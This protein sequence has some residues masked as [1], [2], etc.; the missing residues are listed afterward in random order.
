MTLVTDATGNDLTR[1]LI[2]LAMEVHNEIGPGFKEDV[3]EKA[4]AFKIKKRSIEV[5]RQYKFIVEYE[6]EQ[7]AS[8]ELDLFVAKLVVV[9]IKAFAR[10][11]SRREAT[12]TINYLKT[13]GA[14]VGLLFNFGRSRLEFRR[15]FPGKAIKLTHRAINAPDSEK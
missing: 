3:Y 5:E 9:E 10:P 13:T 2:G 12:Q 8:F 1:I 15:L 11:L 14:P 7:V 6:G 4:M